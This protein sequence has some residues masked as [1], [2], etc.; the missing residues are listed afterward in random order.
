M[1]GLG[2]EKLNSLITEPA[3]VILYMYSYL[4]QLSQFL[5][6]PTLM[7]ETFYITFHTNTTFSSPNAFLLFPYVSSNAGKEY[8]YV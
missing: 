4:S 5:L 6:C 8:I 7:K 1:V 3:Q 2:S